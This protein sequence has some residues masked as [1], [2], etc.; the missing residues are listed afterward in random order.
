MAVARGVRDRVRE[1]DRR[2]PGRVGAGR[3]P[4]TPPHLSR[5]HREIRPGSGDRVGRRVA[6]FRDDV[7]RAMRGV[8]RHGPP[9]VLSVTSVTP[10][11]VRST[12]RP[13]ASGAKR[14]EEHVVLQLGEVHVA[15]RALHVPD[16]RLVR[17]GTVT[18]AHRRHDVPVAERPSVAVAD[19]H[20]I[21]VL[22]IEQDVARQGRVN[23][24]PV[25]GDD[26]DAG[27]KR[28]GQ[29]HTTRSESDAGVAERAANR[30][31]PVERA[32]RPAVARLRSAAASDMG[33]GVDHLGRRF[34]AV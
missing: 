18:R 3:S 25:R 12:Y 2:S 23:G 1:V 16:D 20:D 22:R 26:V 30:V 15:P 14:I 7:E 19:P 10:G 11:G 5:H 21:G 34:R 8:A 33:D 24:R 9:I 13:H 4:K 32:H 29:A 6:D 28:I 27:V 17:N 31:R